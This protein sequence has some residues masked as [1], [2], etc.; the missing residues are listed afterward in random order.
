MRVV[1]RTERLRNSASGNPIWRVHFEDGTARTEPD[2]IFDL[3][4]AEGLHEVVMNEKGRI[5]Q[6]WS[7]PS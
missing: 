7:V 5:A 4:D 6:M 1:R 3:D 2:V